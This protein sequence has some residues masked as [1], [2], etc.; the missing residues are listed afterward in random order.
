VTYP[1]ETIQERLWPL[2]TRGLRDYISRHADLDGT[3][4]S[5]SADPVRDLVRGLNAHEDEFEDASARVRHLI[6]NGFLGADEHSIW[7]AAARDSA[8]PEPAIDERTAQKR[9][10]AAERQ[11]RRRE[12]KR[13]RDADRVTPTVTGVRDSHSVTERDTPPSSPPSALPPLPPSPK[14]LASLAPDARAGGTSERDTE[15][16]AEARDTPHDSVTLIRAHERSE[17]RA[18][19]ESFQARMPD[20]TAWVDETSGKLAAELGLSLAEEIEDLRDYAK[21]R[22]LLSG[23]WNAELRRSMRRH[24]KPSGKVRK[25]APV[26][27]RFYSEGDVFNVPDERPTFAGNLRLKSFELDPRTRMFKCGTDTEGGRWTRDAQGVLHRKP[28][29]P[30]VIEGG[31]PNGTARNGGRG[32]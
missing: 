4:L 27:P 6:A 7:I 10:Q 9:E 20:G 3:L 19:E 13:R 30:K 29:P 16:D 2:F 12:R 31:K 26:E 14:S 15:R 25:E 17:V 23:D 5:N 1:R 18:F 21:S 24:A 32:A 28:P 11:R 8:D 22:S